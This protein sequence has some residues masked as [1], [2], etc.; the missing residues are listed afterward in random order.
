VGKEGVITVFVETDVERKIDTTIN[1]LPG[2]ISFEAARALFSKNPLSNLAIAYSSNGRNFKILPMTIENLPEFSE[3]IDPSIIYDRGRYRVFFFEAAKGG[4]Y[5]CASRDGISYTM[6]EGIRFPYKPTAD[7]IVYR[8]GEI[9]RIFWNGIYGATSKNGM[10]FELDGKLLFPGR[11]PCVF[12]DRDGSYRMLYGVQEKDR[13]STW[14]AR[15]MDGITW[16][17]EGRVEMDPGDIMLAP[18]G[19]YVWY[20]KKVFRD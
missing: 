2:K 16:V 8:F 20:G 19:S 1:V 12:R 13:I 7:L 6:E 5:S 18:D 11:E 17:Q 3:P 15:S 10:D 9:Y 4:I 14:S